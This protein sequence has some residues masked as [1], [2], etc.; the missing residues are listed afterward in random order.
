[1]RKVA[2][3]S[4]SNVDTSMEILSFMDEAAQ[5]AESAVSTDSSVPKNR[6]EIE[7]KKEESK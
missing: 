3:K 4:E 2:G 5:A 6:T 1:M 7:I